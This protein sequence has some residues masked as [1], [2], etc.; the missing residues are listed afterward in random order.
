[1]RAIFDPRED[2]EPLHP[3]RVSKVVKR[4]MVRHGPDR[5]KFHDLR[6]FRVSALIS[7]GGEI[8]K[9]SKIMG[10]KNISV[11]NDL[12]GKIPSIRLTND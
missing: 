8:A 12:Y 10:H 2:G 1:M 3:D 11:T 5:A 7:S 4:T 6:H 9:I